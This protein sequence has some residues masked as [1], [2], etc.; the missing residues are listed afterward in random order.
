MSSHTRYPK[1]MQE[2][3]TLIEKRRK[4]IEKD[5]DLLVLWMKYE[6]LFKFVEMKKNGYIT[7]Q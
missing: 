6:D 7:K 3:E 1:Q 4:Q 5:N 2:I